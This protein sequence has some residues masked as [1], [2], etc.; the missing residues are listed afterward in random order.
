[1]ICKL[2]HT[3]LKFRQLGRKS[4]IEETGFPLLYQLD[5]NGRLLLPLI[6]LADLSEILETLYS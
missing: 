3:G 4:L 1:M 5:K 6:F 2:I